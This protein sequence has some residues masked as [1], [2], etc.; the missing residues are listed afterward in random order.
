LEID[1]NKFN[2]S[3][4]CIDRLG[5]FY[6][7]LIESG[8]RV[9]LIQKNQK[10]FDFSFFLKLSKYLK[11]NNIHII[12][13]H[14]GAFFHGS[15]AGAFAKTQG[16]IYTEHGRHYIEPKLIFLLDH[17]SA[18]FADKI[19]TVSPNLEK[20][21]I[22]KIKLPPKKIKTVINGVNTN[23][24]IPREKSM[25]LLNEFGISA[26]SKIVGSVG[27]LAQIK[28]YGTL[29]KAYKR[30][31]VKIPESRLILVGEGPCENK[32]RDLANGLGISDSVVFLG[33]RSDIPHILNL[34]NVF[35]LPSLREGTSLSLLEAMAS[36]VPTVVTNVG[37]NPNIVKDGYNGFLVESKD[38]EKMAEK[39][40]NLLED[41][42]KAEIFKIYSIN[43][44]KNCFSLRE[45]V[46]KYQNMYFEILN[47]PK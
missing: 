36:G 5:G 25:E 42:E 46:E 43:F 6:E 27:R 23:R 33:N 22:E 3:V 17:I 14:S 44:V 41:I 47:S 7:S 10:H 19:I 8:I 18:F 1:K 30:V 45:N 24:F 9:D 15:L 21:L 20:H 29:I 32:L 39:I 40:I 4:C 12:H 11:K 31:V 35:V 13:I 16:I 28:D 26:N 37:G 34:F 2:V 38:S